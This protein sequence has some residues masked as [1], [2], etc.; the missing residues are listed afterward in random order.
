MRFDD[1]TLV[2]TVSKDGS[3]E[4]DFLAD[5]TL[6][7]VDAEGRSAK[8]VKADGWLRAMSQVHVDRIIIVGAPG[9]LNVKEVPIA[10]EGK[11]WAVK[12][13]YHA[14]EKGRAA[15]AVLGRVGAKIGEDWSI[16][17]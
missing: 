9:S 6:S 10:S 8:S 5:G 2:V 4:G 16:K 12:V 3:A 7:S 17:I 11:T 15:F 13:D 1:Y 14:A